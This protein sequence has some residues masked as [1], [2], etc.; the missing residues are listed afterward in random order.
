MWV[1]VLANG[2][3]VHFVVLT[4]C[5]KGIGQ[6]WD[7]EFCGF[8]VAIIVDYGFDCWEDGRLWWSGGCSHAAACPGAPAAF[9][10]GQFIFNLLLLLLPFLSSYLVHL[11]GSVYQFLL[12]L[13]ISFNHLLNLL[14]FPTLHRLSIAFESKFAHSVLFLIPQLIQQFLRL[15]LCPF[16]L[17]PQ[18]LP[19]KLHPKHACSIR[20]L[21]I[22]SLLK[23]LDQVLFIII[24]AAFMCK[25]PFTI[26]T[27][28]IFYSLL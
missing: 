3:F 2:N 26:H 15:L 28:N 18:R 13:I 19:H 25:S 9:G 22:K 4:R 12:L 8:F 20:L 11:E 16:P 24:R 7:E 1:P 6:L 21:I 27:G 23:L 10:F 17:L 5:S 14:N